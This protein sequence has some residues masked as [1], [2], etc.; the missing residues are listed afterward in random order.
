VCNA[1]AI[2]SGHSARLALQVRYVGDLSAGSRRAPR[3]HWYWRHAQERSTMSRCSSRRYPLFRLVS[4]A[5]Q[6]PCR[7]SSPAKTRV[8]RLPFGALT[9]ENFERLCHR[10]TAQDANLEYCARYGFQ[11]MRRKTST[12]SRASRM[13]A[14]TAF[15]PNVTAATARPQSRGARTT[16][17]LGLQGYT[18]DPPLLEG[19]RTP[20]NRQS[21]Q[22]PPKGR[23][24][25]CC[26]MM[27]RLAT[28]QR[29]RSVTRERATLELHLSPIGYPRAYGVCT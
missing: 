9:W 23:S 21:R 24:R 2:H 4:S 10:L 11:A 15:R 13:V 17:L 20:P 8:Q 18:S 14:I 26:L 5:R 25:L 1:G 7:P 29:F 16:R 27:S 3:Y 28:T 19:G 6:T 22:T 12:F